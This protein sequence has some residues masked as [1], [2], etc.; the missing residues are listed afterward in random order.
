MDRKRSY[1]GCDESRPE[2]RP[3]AEV[4]ESSS[5]ESDSSSSGFSLGSSDFTATKEELERS[6]KFLTYV[7]KVLLQCDEHLDEIRQKHEAAKENVLKDS[8]DDE[9]SVTEG[10]E[11]EQSGTGETTK[12]DEKAEE[13]QDGAGDYV[14][15]GKPTLDFAEFNK[16]TK[17]GSFLKPASSGDPEQ[18]RPLNAVLTSEAEIKV[19]ELKS[20]Q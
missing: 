4:P 1:E 12:P 15:P 11:Q 13:N 19:P 18:P 16:D 14:D 7:D 3:N 9:Q 2:K 8:S 6:Q 20:L 10:A 17:S 5:S